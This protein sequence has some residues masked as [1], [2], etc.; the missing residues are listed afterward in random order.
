M[1]EKLIKQAILRVMILFATV[2]LIIHS[3]IT[4]THAR[5]SPHRKIQTFN[6]NNI[7]PD[8]R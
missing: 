8:H 2:I 7:L 5:I 6:P 3:C 1:Q 4:H